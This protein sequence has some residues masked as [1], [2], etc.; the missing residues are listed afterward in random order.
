MAPVLCGGEAMALQ[1]VV[2]ERVDQH[3]GA[4]LF[5]AAHG[6]LTQVPVAPA[7]MDALADRAALVLRLALLA[8][9]PGA[10]GQHALAV[11]APRPIGIGAVL[12]L[13][14]RTI[15]LYPFAMRPLDVLGGGEAA[16]GEMA[17]R[18]MAT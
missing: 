7:G 9:H 2:G 15:D 5:D 11:A 6:Q 16:V 18:K 10:P 4:H 8:R 3:D 14:G 17:S 1:D 12:G 13:R